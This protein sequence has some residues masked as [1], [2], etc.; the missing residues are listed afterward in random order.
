MTTTFNDKS[1]DQNLKDVGL[2][3]TSQR[4]KIFEI[5]KHRAE[6][7]ERHLTAEEVYKILV[8]EG[9]ETGLATVY[10]VLSQF[11]SAGLLVRRTLQTGTACYELD[12]G[13]H[14]DHLICTVCGKVEE[15]VD[16]GIES[17][18]KEVAKKRGY[19]L[20][21]HMM[22]LFGICSE[23]QKKNKALSTQN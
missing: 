7:G 18:Q 16:A 10:R 2:K 17:R 1:L 15:F 8:Q 14:H 23:C 20:C 9:D 19:V 5:F 4:L 11:V 6:K 12:D 13:R 3:V 22:S 21:D